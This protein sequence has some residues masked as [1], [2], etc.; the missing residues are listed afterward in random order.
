MNLGCLQPPRKQEG[1]KQTDASW[2]VLRVPESSTDGNH[3]GTLQDPT[4]GYLPLYV[5]YI[6]YTHIYI[7]YRIIHIYI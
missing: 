6:V 4:G 7:Y 5:I 3:L 1:A 2:R